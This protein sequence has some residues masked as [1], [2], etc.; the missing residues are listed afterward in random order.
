MP[1]GTITV[2]SVMAAQIA[3]AGISYL[4]SNKSQDQVRALQ[5]EFEEAML[6]RNFERAAEKKRMMQQMR[7]QNDWDAHQ[8]RLS[9]I[10]RNFQN[11]LASAGYK[12]ALST[13]PLITYPFV[14]KDQSIGA[15]MVDG[16]NISNSTV[17]MHCILSKSNDKNFNA[18][19]YSI[20]ENRLSQVIYKNLGAT[21][22][23]P[24]LFYS[25]AAKDNDELGARVHN[26]KE[27]LKDLPVLVITPIIT[28]PNVGQNEVNFHYKVSLWGI[29]NTNGVDGNLCEDTMNMEF[30]PENISYEYRQDQL[31]YTKENVDAIVEEQVAALELFIGYVADMYYWSYYNIAPVLPNLKELFHTSYI[32]EYSNLLNTCV[33][34]MANISE[35]SVNLIKCYDAIK[36]LYSENEKNALLEDISKAYFLNKKDNYIVSDAL[37]MQELHRAYKE[38]GDVYNSSI[39]NTLDS[40]QLITN[41]SL[42]VIELLDN[43]IETLVINIDNLAVETYNAEFFAFCIWNQN[44][45]IGEF[46]SPEYK[47]TVYLSANNAKTFAFICNPES[48]DQCPEIKFYEYNLKTKK[49][50]IMKKDEFNLI[51]GFKKNLAERFIKRGE[52][53]KKSVNTNNKQQ[54]TSKPQHNPWEVPDSSASNNTA[55]DILSYFISGVDNKTIDSKFLVDG[56][57]LSN[58]LEW[59]DTLQNPNANQ[60]YILRGFAE[61]YKKYIYCTF[62][63]FN[64]KPMLEVNNFKFCFICNNESEEIKQIFGDKSI[65]VIPFEN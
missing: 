20:L 47:E 23:H 22:T 15:H 16:G 13:W 17:A 28:P 29:T 31:I 11:L 6:N 25:G 14:M 56:M 30:M 57:S 46:V 34:N 42:T 55:D 5:N 12:Q 63:A 2:L 32:E 27:Q 33:S 35:D 4:R 61:Q 65:Y 39:T 53:L 41:R 7:E 37:F 1:I 40:F 50:A 21:S 3:S 64:D 26:I 36:I 44:I 62:L 58:A 8:F 10:Q 9:G 54:N 52:A 49:N 43:S 24:V 19:V 45:I 60:M 51:D 18:N 59:L 38:N 48:Y